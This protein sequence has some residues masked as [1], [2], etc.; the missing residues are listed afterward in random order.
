[1]NMKSIRKLLLIAVTAAVLLAALG[2]VKQPDGSSEVNNIFRLQAPSFV[3]VASAEE[4]S[5]TSVIEDEAGMA[6][7]FDAGMTINLN[8]VRPVF[9]TIEHET[10]GE[11]IIGSV[12]VTN[13]PES[14][15]VHVY[16]HVDGWILAYYLAADPVG[17]IYDWRAYHDS[18]QTD[19]TTKLENTLIKVASYA[20]VPYPGCTYYDFRYPDATNLM[21]IADWVAGT[22]DSFEVNLPAAFTFD[23]YSWSLGTTDRA[24]YKLDAVTITDVDCN[25]W[26][27][28]QGTFIYEDLL[29]NQFHTI[30]VWG[31]YYN[32]A[33]YAYAG[34]ALVYLVP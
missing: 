21:L 27:T 6:A 17:K 18:G 11:Y 31:E 13:Y 29:P 30:E 22:T 23:E 8:N 16:V 25:T 32:G 20:V 14:E 7:Y 3:A 26:C 4:G 5:I 24:W 19:L 10:P 33:D 28:Y 15:D 34:L 1:M 2:T 9:R 12:E